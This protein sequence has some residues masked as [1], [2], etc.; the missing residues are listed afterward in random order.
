MRAG[1][2][3]GRPRQ[4]GARHRVGWLGNLEKK[5]GVRHGLVREEWRVMGRHGGVTR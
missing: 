1:R 2:E 3:A 5:A 4:W